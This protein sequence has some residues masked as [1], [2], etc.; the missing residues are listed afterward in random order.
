MQNPGSWLYEV[1]PFF[2]ADDDVP[3]YG[4]VGAWSIDAQ[5][6]ITDSFKKNSG[7]R[8]SPQVLGFPEPT[9]QL[10]AAIQLVVAGYGPDGQAVARLLSAEVLVAS[11][12]EDGG[13]SLWVHEVEG[14]EGIFVFSS[15]GQLPREPLFE[16]GAW[17]TVF[18]RDLAASAPDDVDV[19]ININSPA[20]WKVEA[21]RLKASL[22]S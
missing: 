13:G 2:G 8:P 6:R 9:D 15:P 3:P 14:I 11:A 21:Q 4:I 17:R 5:G 19:V 1:D 12:P 18:G 22:A 10:D 7:Y 20:R 16:D